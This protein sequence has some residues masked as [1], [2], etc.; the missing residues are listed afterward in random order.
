[1]PPVRRAAPGFRRTTNPK[2]PSKPASPRPRNPA[3]PA[4]IAS[5]PAAASASQHPAAK[6]RPESNAGFNAAE[7]NPPHSPRTRCFTPPPPQI[8]STL[9]STPA[10]N[11]SVAPAPT[12][13]RQ[14]GAQRT[15][16]TWRHPA[17][18]MR[19]MAVSEAKQGVG[20]CEPS[21]RIS[22][23]YRVRP[24]NHVGEPA[25]HWSAAVPSG[26]STCLPQAN[27]PLRGAVRLVRLVQAARGRRCSQ[28]THDFAVTPGIPDVTEP[29]ER[30]E[31]VSR[32]QK[33]QEAHPFKISQAL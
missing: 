6:S 26:L 29:T 19:R 5:S 25:K 14:G 28:G 10:P 30:C 3:T 17:N 13:R 16:T 11:P 27:L 1:M 33:K 32:Q 12:R 15:E 20:L 24:A 2:R 22:A 31:I 4:P 9:R 18:M 23:A 7:P 21:E 8:L